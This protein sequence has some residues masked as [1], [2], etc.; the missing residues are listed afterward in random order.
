[1]KMLGSDK[2]SSLFCQSMYEEEEKGFYDIDFFVA[3]Q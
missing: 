1:M 2:R 3:L